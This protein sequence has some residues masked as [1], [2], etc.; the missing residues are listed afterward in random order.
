MPSNM[1]AIILRFLAINPGIPSNMRKTRA[2]TRVIRACMVIRA[3]LFRFSKHGTHGSPSKVRGG[4]RQ[5]AARVKF[6][7]A[8]R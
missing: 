6:M 1:R 4:F 2:D 5:R 8:M 3:R 7:N